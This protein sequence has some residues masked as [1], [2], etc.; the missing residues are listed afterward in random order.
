MDF[1]KIYAMPNA[2]PKKPAAHKPIP[3]N[4]AASEPILPSY[5]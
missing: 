5:Y 4:A 2:A 1:A 3:I